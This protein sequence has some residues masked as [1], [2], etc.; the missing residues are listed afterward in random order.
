MT[1]EYR[2]QFCGREVK[3]T[4]HSRN[5]PEGYY[6][7]YYLVWT[8]ELSPIIMKN[9]KEAGEVLQFFKLE[10][11]YPVVAC[12]ECFAKPEVKKE[13]ERAFRE[14]PESKMEDEEED[15]EEEE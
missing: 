5:L 14:L 10:N 11:P 6:V 1:L 7:D 3:E 15:E 4:V 9:P 2:C 8:G 12:A 13:M